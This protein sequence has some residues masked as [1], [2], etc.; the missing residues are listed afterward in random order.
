MS[1]LNSQ[2]ADYD[3]IIRTQAGILGLDLTDYNTLDDEA[4]NIAAHLSNM[5]PYTTIAAFSEAFNAAVGVQMLGNSKTSDEVLG[6][7]EKYVDVLGVTE[8]KTYVVY[9]SSSRVK[10]AVNTR[11]ANKNGY[12]SMD[13]FIAHFNEQVILSGIEQA[14]NQSDVKSI[15]TQNQEFLNINTK[16]FNS[17][18]NQVPVL[19]ALGGKYWETK[20]RLANEFDKQVKLRKD[21]ENLP[22]T[23]NNTGGGRPSTIV[24]PPVSTPT[25]SP[26]PTP[27]VPEPIYNDLGGVSWAVEAIEFLSENEVVSGRGQGVFDPNNLV[28]REE[29]VKMLIAAFADL[30][31]QE[32]ISYSDAA[33]DMWYYPYL[34]AAKHAEIAM[35]KNDGTFGV[36]ESITR[37]DMAVMAVRAAEYAGLSLAAGG[38][39]AFGDEHEISDYAKD[40]VGKMQAAKII[41]G[42][43][44][45]LFAPK[46]F[47]TRAE[48]AKIIYE[49]LQRMLNIAIYDI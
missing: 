32:Q 25:P 48:A 27:K 34:A 11:I 6:L 36:G 44:G 39:E 9:N 28:T 35:G 3:E 45:N 18:K 42:R 30:Q 33:E 38:G 16:D 21:A 49:L 13:D 15:L 20:G 23:G 41:S 22:N 1:N 43:G 40:A 8:E 47:A 10:S 12:S 29:F 31:E 14:I 2:T 17:L 5:R 37:E 4:A 19:S 24:L 26:E 46:D 7:L